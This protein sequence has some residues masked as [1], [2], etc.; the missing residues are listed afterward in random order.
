MKLKLK[1]KLKLIFLNGLYGLSGCMYDSLQSLSHFFSNVDTP[2]YKSIPFSLKVLK[3][4]V[5]VS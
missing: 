3:T 4:D 5:L 2:D 1:L